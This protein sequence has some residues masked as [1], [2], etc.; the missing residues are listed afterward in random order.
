FRRVLFRS[1]IAAILAKAGGVLFDNLPLLFAVGIAIG[2]ARRSDGS[3]ALAAGVGWLVFNPAFK[4]VGGRCP[5]GG[6]GFS[7]T[8]SQTR[9]SRKTSCRSGRTAPPCSP[10]WECSP[11]SSW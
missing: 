7:S 1:N 4:E 10:P 8:P 11:A 9:G 5:A 3:T 2:F 6:R